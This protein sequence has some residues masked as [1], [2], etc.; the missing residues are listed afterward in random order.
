MSEARLTPGY[1]RIDPDDLPSGWTA[2]QLGELVS[3]YQGGRLGL[4]KERDY[5][6]SGVAA[7][8]AA[9]QDGY[10]DQ[11]EFR[12]QRGVVLSA[13][14][15]NCG[16]CFYAEGDWTTLANVQAIVPGPDLDA[17]FLFY[18][19][20]VEN[21]W[22]RS[23]SAQPFIKP[24]SIKHSW[25]A[26][27]PLGHQRRIA[28]ILGTVDEAIDATEALIEKQQ[29]V[30]AGLMHDLF[31][32]GLTPAGQL[33]PPRVEAPA[34]YQE[35]PLGWLPKEWRTA[36]LDD[37]GV[38]IIDGDR[39]ENYPQSHEL[40][41][42][43]ACLFLSAA[44]VTRRGFRFDQLQFVSVEKD[45]LLRTGKLLRG[46]IVI[47][48]R[49]TIGNLAHFDEAIPFT[50]IRINSGMVILRVEQPYLSSD[51]LYSSLTNYIFEREFTRVVSGSAQ[52]Q[53][54]IKDLRR[55][56]CLIP[57]CFE[58]DLLVD[59]VDGIESSLA[60]ETARLAKLREQ[61]QGLMQALLTPPPRGSNLDF[62]AADGFIARQSPS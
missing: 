7:F 22:T 41:S 19:A 43:G 52:P 32:R 12:N 28:E 30:K 36:R 53:L 23:G 29:Q 25:I 57:P 6:S 39:G 56:F 59:R 15:A 21:Y 33:R 24:S 3:L 4:T 46:D 11:A 17:R 61:K 48:T 8:S 49:G 58:Q 31:T 9:G 35:T 55:F 2:R 18:R 38:D 20:N 13:I 47:T 34:L 14:G 37:S 5:V 45:S 42:E 60:A 62:A 26:L 27:P 40:T 16:R 44:N 10:V 54:P 51:F 1:Q 50:D